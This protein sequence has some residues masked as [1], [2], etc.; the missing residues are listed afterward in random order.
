MRRLF[1]GLTGLPLVAGFAFAAQPVPLND[2]QMDG[3]AA[4][5]EAYTQPDSQAFQA[6]AAS[7]PPTPPPSPPPTPTQQ[8][9]TLLSSS[10]IG[11]R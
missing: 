11:L 10:G 4:G 6:I 8:F 2:M 9:S 7:A 3:V 1:V 5:F